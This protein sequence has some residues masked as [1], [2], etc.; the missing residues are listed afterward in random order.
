MGRETYPDVALCHVLA[1]NCA[2]QLVRMP[3]QFD[4]ILADNLFGDMLSDVA[5]MAAGSLGM[6]PSASLGAKRAD[7]RRPALYEPVH[8]SAPDI[9]GKGIA[10]PIAM[11]AS[12]AM[13]LRH[14]LELEDLAAAVERAIASVLAD[15]H[16]TG[17]IA[18]TEHGQIVGTRAMGEA[19]IEALRRE[20]DAKR[21]P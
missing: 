12:L 15:G 13:L 20:S 6:L 2:M 10:N 3:R 1:D 21:A 19:I 5:A 9:A 16:R 18:S 8:G 4:V 14:S 7:G 11:I 17:D